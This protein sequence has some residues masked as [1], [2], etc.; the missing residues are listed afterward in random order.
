[1]FPWSLQEL[2]AM[3]L[4]C[5]SQNGYGFTNMKLDEFRL[6]FIGLVSLNPDQHSRKGDSWGRYNSSRLYSIHSTG[7]TSPLYPHHIPIKSALYPNYNNTIYLSI[8]RSIYL[9]TY[10]YICMYLHPSIHPSIY[11]YLSTSIYIYIY[12]CISIYIYLYI[13]IFIYIYLYLSISIYIYLYLS[14]SI[15]IY[16]YLSI[17]IYIYLNK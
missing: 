8:D 15:Y 4:K 13:S 14:I 16:L 1:M 11:L 12:I 2:G 3:E 5:L 10:I 9:S 6:N 7:S 17:S